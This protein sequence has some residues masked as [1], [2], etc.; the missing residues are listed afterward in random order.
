MSTRVD[1][2]NSW[3]RRDTK[4]NEPTF[5]NNFDTSNKI[6]RSL[7]W[8]TV[9]PLFSGEKQANKKIHAQNN[10][11][12]AILF[13]NSFLQLPNETWKQVLNIWSSSEG[14]MK[15]AFAVNLGP[16]PIQYLAEGVSSF[17]WRSWSCY[18]GSVLSWV[19]VARG[20]VSWTVMPAALS[21]MFGSWTFL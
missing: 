19:I 2:H 14:S 1:F 4:T 5:S 16:T 8:Y 6:K 7:T 11:T 18:L 12:F 10:E 9:Q 15:D 13:C 20:F 3:S 17:R 21:T